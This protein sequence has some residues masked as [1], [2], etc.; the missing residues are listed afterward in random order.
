MAEKIRII[1]KGK[2]VPAKVSKL[3]KCLFIIYNNIR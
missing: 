3:N 2:K 1:S